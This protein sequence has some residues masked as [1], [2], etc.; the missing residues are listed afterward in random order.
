VQHAVVQLELIDRAGLGRV[1]VQAAVPATQAVGS[2][3][4]AERGMHDCVLP[5][6]AERQ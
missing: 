4:V 3:R 1:V 6:E 5:A 2:V